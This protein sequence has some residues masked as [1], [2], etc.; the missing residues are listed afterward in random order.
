MQLSPPPASPGSP[1]REVSG[2][3]SFSSECSS[4]VTPSFCIGAGRWAPSSSHSG[5]S[6][7]SFGLAFLGENAGNLLL[8]LAMSL[9]ATSIVHLIGPW[10]RELGAGSRILAC[11]AAVGGLVVFGYLPLQEVAHR[12]LFFPIVTEQGPVVVRPTRDPAGV[13]RG[14]WIVYW[15]ARFRGNQIIVEEGTGFGPV[16]ALPGETVEF[17]PSFVRVNGKPQPRQPGMPVEG[18]V[19][20]PDAH[21]FVWARFG[22]IRNPVF[23]QGDLQS[24][25]L[26]RSIVPTDGLRGHAYSRWFHRRQVFT[27]LP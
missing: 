27:T 26:D 9:H 4:R 8:G 11:L 22:S 16:L 25:I 20:V 15:Q 17:T 13:R 24:L 19:T 1:H 6:C 5:P 10:L 14:D 7:S 18:S 2:P 3:R 12:T 21:W 23:A